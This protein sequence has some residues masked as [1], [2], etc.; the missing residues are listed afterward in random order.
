MVSSYELDNVHLN[1][2]SELNTLYL[3]V[4]NYKQKCINSFYKNALPRQNKCWFKVTLIPI[5]QV[6]NHKTKRLLKV[7]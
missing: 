6:F 1:T 3:W 5:D 4:D 7:F 2:P